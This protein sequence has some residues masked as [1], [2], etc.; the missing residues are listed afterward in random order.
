MASRSMNLATTIFDVVFVDYHHIV[1]VV[2]AIVG[3]DLAITSFKSFE[4]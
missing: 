3:L 4:C 2:L 1:F